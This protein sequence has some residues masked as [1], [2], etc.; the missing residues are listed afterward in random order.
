MSRPLTMAQ[1]AEEAGLSWERFRKVWRKLCARA[2]FPAP[3]HGRVWDPDAVAAWKAARSGR[4]L[5]TG[6]KPEP[7][8]T[9]HRLRAQRAELQQLRNAP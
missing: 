9:P 1:A 4:A 5:A 6:A 7:S 3:L 8:P 2:G